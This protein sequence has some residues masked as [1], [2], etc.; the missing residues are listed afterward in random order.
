MMPIGIKVDTEGRHASLHKP[1]IIAI[2]L[3]NNTTK[4]C[5]FPIYHD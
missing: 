1:P 2:K 4:R 5:A 3:S